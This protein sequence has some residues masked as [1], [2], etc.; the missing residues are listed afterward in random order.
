MSEFREYI[1]S[2]LIIGLFSISLIMF[3]IGT[4]IDNEADNSIANDPRI[5]TIYNSLN[6]TLESSRATSDSIKT[7]F[8]TENPFVGFGSLLFFSIIGAF[9]T[10]NIIIISIFTTLSVFIIDVIGINP[11]VFSV[12]SAGLLITLVLLGWRLYRQGA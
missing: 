3:A 11:I 4:S 12:I 5:S 9:K 2:F 10:I 6:A 7:S 8:E 1:I